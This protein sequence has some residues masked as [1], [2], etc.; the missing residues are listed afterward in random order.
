MSCAMITN[1]D[2]RT[3]WRDVMWCGRPMSRAPAHITAIYRQTEVHD[4]TN[5][6]ESQSDTQ[7]TTILKHTKSILYYWMEKRER[8]RKKARCGHIIGIAPLTHILYSHE[9]VALDS[10]TRTRARAQ[11]IWH[12]YGRDRQRDNERDRASER[13]ETRRDESYIS[14]N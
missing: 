5:S 14:W 1:A 8:E 13:Y 6:S 9:R 11:R 12:S 7:A 3:I 2:H 4:S 10:I